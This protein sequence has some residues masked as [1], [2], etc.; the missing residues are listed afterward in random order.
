MRTCRVVE[1]AASKT[2]VLRL[3]QCAVLDVSGSQS[4][5]PKSV[6]EGVYSLIH[7]NAQTETNTWCTH[8]M[9]A[10]INSTFFG[11]LHCLRRSKTD[12]LLASRALIKKNSLYFVH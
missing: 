11:N 4:L 12:A 2:G 3:Q 10:I 1:D 5:D 7:A 6:L 8:T 9:N